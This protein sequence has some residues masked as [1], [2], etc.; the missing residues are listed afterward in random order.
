MEIN[1]SDRLPY[2]CY[3]CYRCGRLLTKRHI[4]KM[5]D[6]AEGA[7]LC[8]CGGRHISPGNPLW[9]EELLRPDVW[10]L[11]IMDVVFPWL[12]QLAGRK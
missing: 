2:L 12:R 3:R 9:H 7:A 5:W 4:L 1:E 10:Y 11:W 8:P 6:R